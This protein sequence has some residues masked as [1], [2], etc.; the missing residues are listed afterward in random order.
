MRGRCPR[1]LDEWAVAGAQGTEIECGSGAVRSRTT[2]LVKARK[3]ARARGCRAWSRN[4]GGWTHRSRARSRSGRV[5]E[6]ASRSARS[7]RGRRGSARRQQPHRGAEGGRASAVPTRSPDTYQMDGP[8]ETHVSRGGV[9]VCDEKRRRCEPEICGRGGSELRRPTT[10]PSGSSMGSSRGPSA[11]STGARPSP[12]RER[13]SVA[14][15]SALVRA[16]LEEAEVLAVLRGRLRDVTRTKRRRPPPG[17][18]S[19]RRCRS[20]AGGGSRRELARRACT[21]PS[22]E[23]RRPS[24]SAAERACCA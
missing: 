2:E 24:S 19:R 9:A 22:R 4:R 16:H 15:E 3:P 18:T 14:E 12:G 17:S 5:A 8:S 20:P 23:A 21:T 10:P 6:G 1:P 13:L 11:R 7:R